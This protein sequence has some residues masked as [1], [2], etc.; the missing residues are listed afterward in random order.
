MFIIEVTYGTREHLVYARTAKKADAAAL[1][2]AAIA[3]GYRDARI[4]PESKFRE[5]QDAARRRA[6][7]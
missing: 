1:Q 4:V 2:A 5:A 6:E 7:R 3:H